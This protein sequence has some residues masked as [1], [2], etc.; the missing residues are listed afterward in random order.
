[1]M[2]GRELSVG[3]RGERYGLA[4][5][6]LAA[7]DTAWVLHSSGA[8]GGVV[9]TRGSEGWAKVNEPTRELRDPT[10]DPEALRA[11]E[12][13]LENHG[14]V[15]STGRMG[16]E[17]EREFLPRPEAFGGNPLRLAVVSLPEGPEPSPLRWP[18]SA[19]D[20]VGLLELLT[21]PFP[22]TLQLDPSTWARVFL[23]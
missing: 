6:A 8:L 12:S 10:M 13:Y 3:I 4:H 19:S 7:G 15:G 17:S 5:L 23:P 1:M 16:R 14:W 11:R 2:R 9:Y 21:G 20:E 22:S 18:E